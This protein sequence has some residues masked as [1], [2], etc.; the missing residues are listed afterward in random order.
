M[1]KRSLIEKIRD[2]LRPARNRPNK[3]MT[4][5]QLARAEWVSQYLVRNA[6]QELIELKV[7]RECWEGS[8][9]KY[10]L[11]PVL[12]ERNLTGEC[13]CGRPLPPD[14]AAYCKVCLDVDD[15]AEPQWLPK[16]SVKQKRLLA[17]RYAGANDPWIEF[18]YEGESVVELQQGDSDGEPHS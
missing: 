12:R 3:R 15:P 13:E 8:A 9:R 17:E 5:T 6:L 1:V 11:V 7:V 10:E 14:R 16:G 18:Q 2:R 4:M